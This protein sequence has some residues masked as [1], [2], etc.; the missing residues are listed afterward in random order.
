MYK[1]FSGLFFAVLFFLLV[2]IFPSDSYAQTCGGSFYCQGF[3]DHCTFAGGGGCAGFEDGC[4]C[5]PVCTGSAGPGNS[6]SY[7][8][9]SASC[10]SV[11][12]YAC[13]E[14][15]CGYWSGSC[16]WN[17][18]GGGY[19]PPPSTCGNGTC[20]S[21]ESCSSCATDCGTCPSPQPADP[22]NGGARSY[23]NGGSSPY[24]CCGSNLVCSPNSPSDSSFSC[25]PPTPPPSCAGGSNVCA[26]TCY[27]G[28]NTSGSPACAAN[29]GYY[30][31]DKCCN[32]PNNS[33]T[34]PATP[35]PT[36]L[37][38]CKTVGQS[39]GVGCCS[40]L[41]CNVATSTCVA[42][43]TLTPTSPPG[44]T[45]ASIGGFCAASGTS[46]L[47]AGCP[48][49]K[50]RVAR[51]TYNCSG[52]TNT[53]YT[54]QAAP[55]Q[56]ATPTQP[57][58]PSCES[59]GLQTCSGASIYCCQLNEVCGPDTWNP[60]VVPS[61]SVPYRCAFNRC[62]GQNTCTY[63][64]YQIS[65]PM[66][67]CPS[68]NCSVD[69][70]CGPPPTPNPNMLK[71]NLYMDLNKDGVKQG[72]ETFF[73]GTGL[74]LRI[75]ADSTTKTYCGSSLTRNT[76]GVYEFL[77][78][79]DP[80]CRTRLVNIT[81]IEGDVNSLNYRITPGRVESLLKSIAFGASP[82][83]VP[84]PNPINFG[85]WPV[86][87]I[88]GRNVNSAGT[89]N[90][91]SGAGVTIIG[92]SAGGSSTQTRSTTPWDFTDIWAGNYSIT[93][94]N[95]LG[96]NISY[97][98]F[99]GNCGSTGGSDVS[100]TT[101]Q[102][103]VG[104]SFTKNL[105]Q[106]G[107]SLDL[108]FR[109][110]VAP[111]P[112][113]P[114]NLASA[115]DVDLDGYV[116]NDDAQMVSDHVLGK[117]VLTGSQ[118]KRGDVTLPLGT[119]NLSDATAISGYSN[120]SITTFPACSTATLTQSPTPTVSCSG[121]QTITGTVWRDTGGTICTSGTTVF[122]NI[123]VNF[124][125]T[126]TS[127]VV[128]SPAPL[129][130]ASGIYT[131]SDNPRVCTGTRTLTIQPPSTYSVI[132]L[133]IDG[134]W[135]SPAYSSFTSP[136]I[137]TLNHTIDW[138]VSDTTPWYQTGTGDVRYPSIL[139]KL[140]SGQ[141]ASADSTNPSV[142][143]S[144]DDLL[145]GAFGAGAASFKNWQVAD[146]YSYNSDFE[147]GLGTM[148]YSFYNSQKRKKGITNT[149]ISGSSYSFNDSITSGIYVFTNNSVQIN[150]SSL[151]AASSN[152]HII[153]LAPG[154]VIIAGPITIFPGQGNL[155]ILAAY[156]N[157][158]INHGVGV[159]A[160]VNGTTSLDGYYTAEGNIILAHNPAATCTPA[161]NRDLR[162]NVSG[163]LIANSLRPF[164]VGQSGKLMNQRTLCSSNSV[165]PTFTVTS[166]FE[167]LTQL[168]DFYKTTY[169]TY[170]EVNP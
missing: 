25:V 58:P 164:S 122:P 68:S 11:T 45:C 147:N 5:S 89:Q 97:M 35:T 124:N 1:L 62:T 69:D 70:D 53:C 37:A 72:A 49:G 93:A 41:T 144:S 132:G 95:V 50:V 117:I 55:T 19:V 161:T 123:T 60:C 52:S 28:E 100:L 33:P 39:C 48:A 153:I 112:P 57:P 14:T 140:P 108:R 42:V 63:D 111:L 114:C 88:L 107:N 43:A 4:M 169:K 24:F 155:F 96:Y 23:C 46:G 8:S 78:Q 135:Q 104:R 91:P 167:F 9:D 154:N 36:I 133:R 118:F 77:N 121:A 148:S 145:T 134:V 152:K 84:N 137:D 113:I 106:G 101:G 51:G 143:F 138:C 170:K 149:V 38:G 2:L 130:N 131:A 83:Y 85:I 76:S 66:Q 136:T 21:G 81:S 150:T 92:P 115:G 59:Q 73:T 27:N 67:T 127:P 116:T 31:G 18:G 87:T 151:T 125:R 158:T 3:Y 17:P 13:S 44:A 71:G 79:Y 30:G 110:A 139:N 80:S 109:Y 82:N 94:N 40:G 75:T 160:A 86:V 47:S 102:Y 103:Y 29:P 126:G 34:Q 90:P 16:S 142:F 6:C 99:G 105:P 7:S 10:G 56:P 165:F 129:T 120:G 157:I 98:C 156:G 159:D 26:Y 54:C 128:K 162:L 119:L 20:N 163:A 74:S 12:S 15:P 166:R 146:E 61:P 141:K 168:T 22:C 64:A 65:D 32:V